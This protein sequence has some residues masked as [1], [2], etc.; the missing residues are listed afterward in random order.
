MQC[1]NN[2]NGQFLLQQD[3][4]GKYGY[5]FSEK[6]KICVQQNVCE[7]FIVICHC[8][9]LVFFSAVDKITPCYAYYDM[10][11]DEYM[12]LSQYAQFEMWLRVRNTLIT[13]YYRQRKYM[14]LPNAFSFIEFG[15]NIIARRRESHRVAAYLYTKL[16]DRYQHN[17]ECRIS[18]FKFAI[19]TPSD[20]T[21][22]DLEF[23]NIRMT[24]MH[25]SSKLRTPLSLRSMAAAKFIPRLPK[26][27]LFLLHELYMIF[28]GSGIVVKCGK[29]AFRSVFRFQDIVLA[30]IHGA[31]HL[32]FVEYLCVLNEIVIDPQPYCVLCAHLMFAH[33]DESMF[34]ESTI[35]AFIL[36]TRF[37]TSIYEQKTHFSNCMDVPARRVDVVNMGGG[38]NNNDNNARDEDDDDESDTD[39]AEDE[40]IDDITQ[41]VW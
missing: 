23:M 30:F 27:P 25:P 17:P 36:M 14:L 21:K 31:L 34:G 7:Q 1:G 33:I 13:E 18:Q 10:T 32:P 6:I 22:R 16:R 41:Y 9:F 26:L 40:G 28:H 19:E 39:D 37:G 29:P 11:R 35:L 2:P 4:D 38:N 12:D 3:L 24:P 15:E 5:K 20:G 8:F